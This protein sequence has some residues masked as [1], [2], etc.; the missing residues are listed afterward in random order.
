M[1]HWRLLLSG[2]FIGVLALFFWFEINTGQ[3]GIL[4]FPLALLI[5][6]LAAGE[7]IQLLTFPGGR[8]LNWTVYAGSLLVVGAT[9]IPH[10][11]PGYPLDCP[12]GNLGWPFLAFVLAI[13]LAIAGEV[14]RFS[15]GPASTLNLSLT[16]YGIFTIGILMSFIVQLRFVGG[17]EWQGLP[18]IA[19]LI[20]VKACD[21]GAYTIGRLIGKHKLAPRLSPGKTLEGVGGG[22]LFAIA[23]S[24]FAFSVLPLWISSSLPSLPWWWIVGYGLLVG[25]TGILGDLSESMLK[26]CADRKDSS[27]W[28]PGFG[29]IL[30]LLDSP[31]LAAPIAYLLWVGCRP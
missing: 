19:M 6:L 3:P 1:L 9:G 31:L 12:F 22:I 29:G 8:P 15:P 27:R 11:W 21:I 20:V 7:I 26:R 17:P 13:T 16:I 24:W 23:G 10:F 18:L 5:T 14:L 4:L 30:D 28:M 2:L 25:G